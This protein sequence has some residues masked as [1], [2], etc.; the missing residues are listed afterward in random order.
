MSTR[1]LVV[2]LGNPDRG[3]DGVGPAV[4]AAARRLLPDTVRVVVHDGPLALLDG[5]DG[6]DE[7]VVVD[8]VRTGQRPGTVV[9]VDVGVAPLPAGSSGG[10]THA[11]GLEATIELARALHR[12]PPRLM[13]VG[14][15]GARFDVG[16]AMS[17]EVDDARRP[18]VR[19]V[20]DLVSHAPVQEH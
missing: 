4:V 2:G 15:E 8:A 19:A 16:A 9:V 6:Y 20:T 14:V 10:G 1:S 12:L 5:W 3:D 11:F 7:V 18:A 17:P 13:L